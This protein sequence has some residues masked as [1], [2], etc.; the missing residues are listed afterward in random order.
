MKTKTIT[1]KPSFLPSFCYNHFS[2]KNNISRCV[3]RFC[4]LPTTEN[5]ST[6]QLAAGVTPFVLW[7]WRSRCTSRTRCQAGGDGEEYAVSSGKIQVWELEFHN[8][9][10]HIMLHLCVFLQGEGCILFQ[11]RDADLCYSNEKNEKHFQEWSSLGYRRIS[12]TLQLWFT[13]GLSCVP[14]TEKSK[15]LKVTKHDWAVFWHLILRTQNIIYFAPWRNDPIWLVFYK[16]AQSPTS[17]VDWLSSTC[18]VLQEANA[19]TLMVLFWC[20]ESNTV[21]CS[22]PWAHFLGGERVGLGAGGVGGS[23]MSK[24]MSDT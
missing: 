14:L 23:G 17:L 4:P 3:I 5:Q 8:R 21:G 9:F 1:K 12:C 15:P 24:K 18:W 2:K 16:V 20:L 10:V 6:N 22:S 11:W 7:G 13:S 19:W